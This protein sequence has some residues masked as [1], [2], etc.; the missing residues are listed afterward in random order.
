[1]SR[2]LLLDLFCSA[3][4]CSKGYHDA[5]FDVIGVDHLPQK[6]YPYGFVQADALEYLDNTDLS[7]FSAI[8]ASPPCQSYSRTSHFPKANLE[9]APKMIYPVRERLVASGKPW[10]IENVVG[11]SLPDAIQLCGSMFGLPAI[12]HR[13]FSCSHLLFAPCSCK[14]AKGF[15][16]PVGGKIRGYGD[17]ASGTTYLDAQGRTHR[18]EGYYTRAIGSQAM[19]IDWMTIP[20]LCQAIPPAYTEWIGS[21]LMNVLEYERSIAI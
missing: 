6:N 3:G 4:G 12:R 18:R 19:G 1:M 20:E 10:V 14:H 15:Y 5:G 7:R 13:W 17:F 21:Q 9:P 2:P 8:A 11:S 16:N